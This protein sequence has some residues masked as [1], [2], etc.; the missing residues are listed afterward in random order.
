V[1]LFLGL[2][3]VGGIVDHHCLNYLSIIVDYTV[4]LVYS[5]H[6]GGD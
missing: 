4:K 5:G 6:L 3:I 2:N 1:N